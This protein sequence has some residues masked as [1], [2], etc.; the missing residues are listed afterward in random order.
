VRSIF[1][2]VICSFCLVVSTT[3]Q[4]VVLPQNPL[5]QR[6]LGRAGED[7]L[8]SL[9]VNWRGDIAAV[10][11]AAKGSQ[12]GNDIS[13]VVFDAQLNK[14]VNRHIGRQ[15]DDGAGQIAVLPDGRYVVAG[16][17][18]RPGGRSK[19]K[20]SYFGKRDGWVLILNEKGEPEHEI[21]L[22][23]EADDVFVSVNTDLEGRIWLSGNSGNA[24]WLVQLNTQL[25]VQWEQ[26]VQYHQLPTKSFAAVV[27]ER[28][29][30]FVLGG[31]EELNRA[32]LWVAG[33]NQGGNPIMEKIYP[34]SQAEQGASI[35]AINADSLVIIGSIYDP[36][37]RENGFVSLLDRTGVMRYYHALGGREY[38]QLHHLLHLHNGQLMVGGGSASFE[39][40]SRRISAWFSL[41]DA[42]GKV[43]QDVFYGSKLDDEALAM[44]EHPDGR[45]FAVGVTARQVLKNRQ[46]WLF[47]LTNRSQR[48]AKSNQLHPVLGQ[49]K[50]PPAS[51]FLTNER[52]TVPFSIHNSDKKGQCNLRAVISSEAENNMDVLLLPGRR[53][54]ILP[55]IRA[56]ETLNWGFPLQFRP[57]TPPGIYTWQIQFYQGDTPLGAPQKLEVKLGKADIPRLSVNL[58]QT[59]K[60]LVLGQP[61]T[62][63]AEIANTGTLAANGVQLS[64]AGLPGIRLPE[65]QDLGTILPGQV[66]QHQLVLTPENVGIGPVALPLRIRV[67]DASLIHTAK[68][69]AEFTVI[70]PPNAVEAPAKP[71]FTLAVW[72]YPN[73]D[74][75]DRSS[76]VWSQEEITVQIKIVSSQPVTRQQF[77]LEINGQPCQTGA[78]FDEV[79]IKGDRTSKTFS[80]TIRLQEGENSLLAFIQQQSGRINSEPLKII[81]APSKPNLHI[82]SIGVPAADLKYPGKDARD[83]AA[84]LATTDNRAFAKIFL[85][86]LFSEEKTTKTEIL[87]SLRRLQYRYSDL[88]I[89]P[90]DLLV[91]FVSGHGLGAYDGSF[92]LAASDYDSP[93][94]QETSLDFEQ[95][96]VNYL[97]S[98]P[99]KK[100]FLVDAC[101][102]GTATGSGL[103]GIAARKNGLNM[104]VSCQSD[105][106]SYEDDV[107]QNGAFTRALVRG[108]ETFI[109]TPELVDKNGDKILDIVELF[110]FVQKAVPALIEKKKPKPK[111]SQHPNL[112]MHETTTPVV[113]F[114]L[115]Q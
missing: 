55:T 10:G 109:T 22:G 71:E 2:F 62:I 13:F 113:L 93:F 92:R 73:P 88:Q 3:G 33:F 21:I 60:E 38:D 65:P 53:S 106:Y 31:I 6:I 14:I 76:I 98:L 16:F 58:T 24:V 34:S 87:K 20:V 25:E 48:E 95:E 85:D 59:S 99:C 57:Q 110:G 102:S 70:A 36:N 12:G 8:S 72:V 35:A 23:T 49:V 64:A 112:V 84:A 80:Q 40:G 78:K 1:C 19:T 52:V 91:V 97:Q 79:Q 83:F 15:G 96:M 67:A 107:W 86:T 45:L 5:S 47:Q 4:S 89:S 46:G 50:Y 39:R 51:D 43:Q 69:E 7:E 26:K 81:Y 63:T 77:C 54:V 61:A 42:D 103:A 115:K 18:T 114:E 101:H 105:E 37:Q 74:N 68:T 30:I 17:S 82:V 9:T 32:H 56:G 104:L 111:T 75:F 108:I 90:K 27:T 100:L 11:N 66:V 28:S 41:L 94:V 29:E 44:I